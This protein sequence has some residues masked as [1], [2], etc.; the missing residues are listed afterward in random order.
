MFQ[1]HV[2]YVPVNS[3]GCV[4]VEDVISAITKET[5]L[6]SLMLAN[7]ETGA[8]QPVREVAEYCRQ[9]DILFHTDAAQA[10]GKVSISIEPQVKGEIGGIGDC[11]MVTIVGHKFGSPKGIACLYIRPGCL[12][13]KGRCMPTSWLIGGNQEY[14]RRAGTENVPYI[15]AMGTAAK[16]LMA[17][18]SSRS[19]P[20]WEINAENMEDMRCRLLKKLKDLLGEDTIREHG[21][22]DAKY[23]LPN[24]LSVG[25]KNVNS[26]DLLSRIRD[27]VACSAGSACHSKGG[28]V[29]SVLLAMNIPPE[30]AS[31]T[32]RLSV[33]PDTTALDVDTAACIIADE[34]KKMIR[35]GTIV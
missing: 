35:D 34:V 10:V 32:L 21:P 6:V 16:R 11:D 28:T 12:S 33:G 8:L 14:G 19:K 3:H 29:S 20:R 25:L 1:I 27:Q 22:T 2:T 13:V 31:G 24:T 15:V 17:Q 26:A 9:H 23:R 30:Y 5:V 18:D 7:N 4:S